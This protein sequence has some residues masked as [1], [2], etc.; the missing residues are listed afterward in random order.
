MAVRTAYDEVRYSNHPYAQTH[1]DRLA[2][3]AALHGLPAPAP[4]A[5]RVLELGCGAGGNLHAMAAATPGLRAIGIDLAAGPIAEA[6][7]AAEA[8]GLD[9][10]EFRQGDLTALQ[11]G[12]LGEFDYVIAHGVY[13]WVPAATRE[14]LLASIHSHLAAD[15]LA[16][17]SYNAY[18]GGYLRR[19]L[20]EAGLWFARGEP[21]GP[22]E[23]AERA[24]VLFR[25][26]LEER[27]DEGDPWGSVLAKTLP[28]LVEGPVYRLVHDDLGDAWEPI[29]F[30]DFVDHAA[31]HRL[32]YVGDADLGNLLPARLP[33]EIEPGL[34]EL[35]A[36]DRIVREQITDLL[37][38]NFFRQSVL[39]RDTRTAAPDPTPDAMYGLS[40]AARP[41]GGAAPSGLLADVLEPLRAHA[42]E[43]I[44]F[45]E[46]RR[47]LGAEAEPLAEALLEGF[48]T[49]L[50]MPHTEPLRMAAS[51]VER[52]VASGLARWQAAQGPE[53]TSLA[54]T[55]VHMEEPAARVLITLLDGSRDRAGV[56]AEFAERTGV[57]LSAEDLD[58]NL[59]ELGRLFILAP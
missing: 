5:C 20:R 10:L 18:P 40:F 37:R 29:W 45:G 52:P 48:R 56:R 35:A 49:E 27:A 36:G 9:G 22:A 30:G 14:A 13:A 15:G 50:V 26:L 24:R 42:P 8:V 32:G 58:A 34:R 21:G 25:Y 39:C 17:V 43:T 31:R 6:R 12:E 28:P 23:T 16:F 38:C 19:A 57:R 1:P 44:A 7:R 47:A 51:D 33:G 11:N 46:L 4:S 59:A 54:Y 55:N 53:V 41:R 3:V 2:T